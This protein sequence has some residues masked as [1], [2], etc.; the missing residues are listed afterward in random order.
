MDEEEIICVSFGKEIAVRDFLVTGKK[1][2]GK[3]V[4]LCRIGVNYRPG[5]WIN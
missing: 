5:W 1:E 3:D 4:V 2:R